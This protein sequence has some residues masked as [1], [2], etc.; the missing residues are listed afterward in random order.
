MVLDAAPMIDEH[1]RIDV[2][3]HQEG[4]YHKFPCYHHQKRP[5]GKFDCFDIVTSSWRALVA[6]A[7]IL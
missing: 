2:R 1:Q 3:I 4:L 6:D 7:V 5:G